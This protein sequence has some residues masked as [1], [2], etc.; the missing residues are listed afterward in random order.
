V[1]AGLYLSSR[2]HGF[3]AN[4][5]LGEGNYWPSKFL[6]KPE[7]QTYP[8]ARAKTLLSLGYFLFMFQR[9]AE[10]RAAAQECLDLYRACGDKQGEIDGLLL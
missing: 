5:D 7:S 4:F 8:R 6:Q 9:F 1:E 10:S 3:W 2:L